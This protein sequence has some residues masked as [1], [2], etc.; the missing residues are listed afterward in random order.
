MAWGLERADELG[1]D[2][3][4]EASPMGRG[5]YEKSGFVFQGDMTIDVPERFAGREVL[6]YASLIRPAKASQLLAIQTRGEES[7]SV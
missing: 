5:L 6:Q 4:V 3:F 2:V 1:F 7:I